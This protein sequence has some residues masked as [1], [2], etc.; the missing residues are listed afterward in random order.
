MAKKKLGGSAGVSAASAVTIADVVAL[1]QA[2]REQTL[3][4][5]AAFRAALERSRKTLPKATQMTKEE[6]QT[7]N[8]RVSAVE[9][10]ILEKILDVIDAHPEVFAS[11]ASKDHGK[12]PKKVETDPARHAIDLLEE[13]VPLVEELQQA[14]RQAGDLA[15]RLGE[16]VRDV[17]TPAYAIGNANAPINDALRSDMA[18]INDDYRKRSQA[19]TGEKKTRKAA[20]TG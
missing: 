8:G 13:L 14:A 20:P 3:G 10:P 15:L 18:G 12:D 6:R 19:S 16:I 4:L 1:L 11:L 7:S 5:I 9:L 17:T 2:N